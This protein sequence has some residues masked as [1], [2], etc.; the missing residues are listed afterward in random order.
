M[1]HPTAVRV[2]SPN[3]MS[4]PT[5]KI[6][7]CPSTLTIEADPPYISISYLIF[8]VVSYFDRSTAMAEREAES[9][10][11]SIRDSFC[12]C[13]YTM[14]GVGFLASKGKSVTINDPDNHPSN[15][16]LTLLLAPLLI[17]IINSHIIPL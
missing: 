7:T 15:K 11:I 16:F 3:I 5:N 8:T 14:H 6:I 10:A 1:L 2:Q 12:V 17:L 4:S 13:V 9:A